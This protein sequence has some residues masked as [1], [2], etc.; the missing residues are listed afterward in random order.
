MKKLLLAAAA[1]LTTTAAFADDRVLNADQEKALEIFRTVISMRTSKGNG[2]VPAMAA[3][4]A[5]ELKA[6]GFADEDIQIL[7]KDETAA[8]V[9]RYRGDGS[10]GKKP[11]LF[12]GHMDVVD[13]RPEDW[14]LN[15]FELT[16]KDGYYFGRGVT[17]NKYGITNLT[18]TFIRLKKQGF[19]PTR[20]LV[21]AFSGDEESGMITTRML[22]Y[23]RK[24]LTDA[25]FALNSD[26]GGGSLTPD[27]APISYGVQA[28]EK[29]FASFFITARNPGGHS[30]RPRKDNAIYDLVHALGRIEKY[31]FPAMS[32]AITLA[33]FA[34]MGPAVGGDIGKAMVEF[35][36]NPSNK[37]AAAKIAADPAYLGMTRTTCVA[38]MLSAG[39][40]ENALPQTATATVNCRIFPGVEVDA[41]KATLADVIDNDALEIV[42]DGEPTASPVSDMRDDV[43]AALSKAVHA[44]YPGLKIGAYQ[45]SGGTDGMH[46]RK[47]DVPTLAM[48]AL[49]MNEGD[50]YA[51][52]LNERIPVDAFFGGLDHWMIIMNELAGRDKSAD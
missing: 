7:P 38:T 5:G 18:Q 40:A 51:H 26:A 36:E 10:S 8:L 1:A 2:Q 20:D 3:Y 32:N 48:S 46:F 50:M 41:V 24:D 19:V 16:E 27:G 29:T 17:D 34:D 9:V 31:E 33:S 13:A 45:E 47:A 37:K 49:F 11:I 21:L 39:H 35:A 4:L 6:A 22:A 23:D 14:E 15:P 12:L 44:R 42:V 43:T 52:G 28:A 30:S 25:E